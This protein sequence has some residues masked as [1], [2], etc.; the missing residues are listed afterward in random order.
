MKK[1]ILA[2]VAAISSLS[3]M[4]AQQTTEAAIMSENMEETKAPASRSLLLGVTAGAN[5]STYS[6]DRDPNMGFGGQIGINCDVPI[7]QY[8]SIMPELIFAY[9]T[10]KIDDVFLNNNNERI[11]MESTDKMLY[12]SVPVNVKGSMHLGIGRPFIAV[13]PMISVGLYG[14]NDVGDSEILL[15]QSDSNSEFKEYREN[16]PYNNVDFAIN[17]KAG[18]DFDFGLSVS[19]AFQLGL[20]NMYKMPD[21]RKTLYKEMGLDTTQKSRSFSLVLGYNF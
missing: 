2:C 14:Q 16:P 20:V 15:F 19:A 12:M 21:S 8:F 17:F 7:D 6:S 5:M 10:V 11:S 4:S 1:I 13:G 9:K 18:Y 3:F